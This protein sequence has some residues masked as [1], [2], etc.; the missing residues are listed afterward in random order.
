M[1]KSEGEMLC[2]LGFLQICTGLKALKRTEKGKFEEDSV[3]YIKNLVDTAENLPHSGENAPRILIE[4]NK[5]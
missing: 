5:S 2:F 4:T 3:P 1:G